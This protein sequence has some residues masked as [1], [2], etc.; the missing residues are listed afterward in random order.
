MNIAAFW[1]ELWPKKKS[2]IPPDFWWWQFLMFSTSNFCTFF[3]AVVTRLKMTN[4]TIRFGAYKSGCDIPIPGDLGDYITGSVLS[5]PQKLCVG[6]GWL[7]VSTRSPWDGQWIWR[8]SMRKNDCNPVNILPDDWAL[9]EPAA[10]TTAY[11]TK[12]LMWMN[13]RGCSSS[14]KKYFPTKLF[15]FE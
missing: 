2:T 7:E 4:H 3:Y 6:F 5:N 13:L 15:S 14:V 9:S 1:T 10:V 11:T 8:R 12:W